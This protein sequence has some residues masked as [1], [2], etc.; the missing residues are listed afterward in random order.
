M[1]YMY[2]FFGILNWPK[3]G[4]FLGLG[5]SSTFRLPVIHVFFQESCSWESDKLFVVV[6]AKF[7]QKT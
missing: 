1:F 6:T 4:M 5:F 7:W 2:V 3:I